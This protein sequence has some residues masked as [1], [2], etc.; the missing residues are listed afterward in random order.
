MTLYRYAMKVLLGDLQQHFN[1]TIGSVIIVSPQITSTIL[2]NC[3]NLVS[4]LIKFSLIDLNQ[5]LNNQDRYVVP[6]F[7]HRENR[8]FIQEFSDPEI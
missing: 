4:K 8:Y 2:L 1:K 5:N 3:I 7:I 6:T